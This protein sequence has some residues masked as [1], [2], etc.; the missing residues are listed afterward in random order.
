MIFLAQ[1]KKAKEKKHAKKTLK[2]ALLAFKL[3]NTF[4]L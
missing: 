4:S 1:P 3:F 2:K